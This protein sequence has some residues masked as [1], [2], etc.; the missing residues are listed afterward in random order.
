MLLIVGC[1]TAN[2]QQ[3]LEEETQEDPSTEQPSV[4]DEGVDNEDDRLAVEHEFTNNFLVEIDVEPGFHQMRGK[5]DGFEMLIPENG[6]ISDLLHATENNDAET[7]IYTFNNEPEKKLYDV[8]VMYQSH[9]PE[10]LEQ[11]YLNVFKHANNFEGE[12]E[13]TEVNDLEVYYGSYEDEDEYGP[14]LK[15]FGYLFSADNN[16]LISFSFTVMC[17]GEENCNFNHEEEAE[18]AEKLMYSIRLLDQ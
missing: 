7:V 6:I 15:Y 18:M 3:E 5:L 17:Q 10:G 11:S 9:Y 12:Y 8:Q 16:Q 2:N 13:Y 14:Y 1:N 4:E